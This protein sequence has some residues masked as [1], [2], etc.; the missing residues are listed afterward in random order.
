MYG[1]AI[2][3][4]YLNNISFSTIRGR[5]HRLYQRNWEDGFLLCLSIILTKIRYKIFIFVKVVLKIVFL[6]S[7]D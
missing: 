6:F 4:Y 7:L 3:Q 2:S 5:F 1:S